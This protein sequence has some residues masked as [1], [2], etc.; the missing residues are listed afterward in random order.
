[1]RANLEKLIPG[2][3]RKC[4]TLQLSPIFDLSQCESEVSVMIVKDF[5][6][7]DIAEIFGKTPKTIY[8]HSGKS[9]RKS[10]CNTLPGMAIK[11]KKYFPDL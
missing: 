10:R 2:F 6:I 1:M 4:E 11:I 9:L 5:A 8:A 7:K 3:Y